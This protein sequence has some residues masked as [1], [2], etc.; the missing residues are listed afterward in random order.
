VLAWRIA[1]AVRDGSWAV[2]RYF[3]AAVWC[4][5]GARTPLTSS[6]RSYCRFFSATLLGERDRGMIE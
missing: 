6:M 4:K 1:V 2:F 5:S 3:G